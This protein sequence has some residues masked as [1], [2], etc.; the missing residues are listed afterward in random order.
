MITGGRCGSKKGFLSVLKYGLKVK[1]YLNVNFVSP[2]GAWCLK[3]SNTD[4]HHSYIVFSFS[5]RKTSCYLFENN[6][7][8]HTNELRLDES[9]TSLHVNKLADGSIVQVTASKIRHIQNHHRDICIKG[10]I[11]KAAC[12]AE[13]RQLVI[14]LIGGFM[15]YYELNSN[16]E[17]KLVNE[18]NLDSEANF[19]DFAPPDGNDSRALSKLIVIGKTNYNISIF[20]LEGKGL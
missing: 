9:E 7:L 18:F 4:R 10:R 20:T 12:L 3:R 8:S 11:M 13:G 5:N 1:E 16:G 2:I 15:E 14:L 19:I 17:L 6:M